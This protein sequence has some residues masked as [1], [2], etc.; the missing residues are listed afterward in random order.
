MVHVVV[1]PDALP[2]AVAVVSGKWSVGESVWVEPL[3][4]GSREYSS[5]DILRWNEPASVLAVSAD[6]V[7]GGTKDIISIFKQAFQIHE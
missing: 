4:V 7:V 6:D 5:K 3:H 2:S 1:V